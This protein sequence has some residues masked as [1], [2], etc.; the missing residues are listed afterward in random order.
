[1]ALDVTVVVAVVVVSVV[2]AEVVAVVVVGVVEVVGV[3]VAV[4]VVVGVVTSH[5]V[6]MPS[7]T[8]KYCSTIP[9]SRLATSAQPSFGTTKTDPK[10]E[11]VGVASSLSGP[12]NSVVASF[13]TAATVS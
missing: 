7:P 3:V 10:H 12:I 13:K 1:M 9:L 6:N 11:I 4:V 5:S 8:S 2:V